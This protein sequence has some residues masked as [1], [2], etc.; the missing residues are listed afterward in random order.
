M[1]LLVA[2]LMLGP[3]GDR[4]LAIEHKVSVVFGILSGLAGIAT[5]VQVNQ[6]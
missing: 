2:I 1:N 5:L 6:G 4:G 3:V